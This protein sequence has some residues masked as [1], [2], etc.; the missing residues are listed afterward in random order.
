[1]NAPSAAYDCRNKSQEIA[2]QHPVVKPCHLKVIHLHSNASKDIYKHCAGVKNHKS[3][4]EEYSS[5]D[6]SPPEG[7]Q[8][9]IGRTP[10]SLQP[11]KESH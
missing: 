9:E 2:K 5:K 11:Y 1:M 7:L 10:C 4:K 3:Y 6:A 8:Q